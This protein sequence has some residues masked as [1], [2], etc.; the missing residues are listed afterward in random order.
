[1][2]TR[3]I[4][5]LLAILLNLSFTACGTT[6]EPENTDITD[7]HPPSSAENGQQETNVVE[8]ADFEITSG[9]RNSYEYEFSEFNL[10]N[11]SYTTLTGRKMPYKLRG[12]MAVPVGEG[13]FPIVLITHGSHEN[14]DETKRFDTGYDYL[15]KA[16]AQN[17][18]AAISMDMLMPY[19]WTYGDDDDMEKSIAVADE[20][21]K[22]LLKASGGE[23]LYPIDLTNRTDMDKIALIGHSRGGETIFQIAEKQRENG[24]NIETLLSIAPSWDI[25]REFPDVSATIIVP[26]YDGDVTRLDGIALYDYLVNNNNGDYSVTFLMGA[27][28]N[29]FNRNIERDDSTFHEVENGHSALS[30][31]EQEEF[32]VNYAVDFLDVS[33]GIEDRFY[34]LSQPQPNK[35]YGLDI[36]RSVHFNSAI[37]L[38]DMTAAGNFSSD[39]A[40]VKHVVDSWFFKEDHILIDTVTIGLIDENLNQIN[41][42]RDLISIEWDNMDSIVNIIPLKSDF[43]GKNALS[44]HLVLDSASALNRTNEALQFTIILRDTEGNAASVVTA[45]GQNILSCY[46]GRLVKTQL[47]DSILEYWQPATPLGTLNIPLSLFEGVNLTAIKSIELLF[48]Q[49]DS[50]SIFIGGIEVQ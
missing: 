24:I 36:S 1:M 5:L 19:I 27:N 45:A 40:V 29:F 2:K 17:G 44:I 23:V 37:S 38:T 26:Q 22:S 31:Q 46:P 16:L 50:G 7:S 8:I 48:D 4:F 18:Y 32:L 41:L 42:N 20:H 43:N 15:V 12:I 6:Q 33:F 30:R 25:S 10:G 9:I 47:T 49:N 35:M 11:R 34:Q 3:R 28:H 13:P 14:L 39:T 21:I